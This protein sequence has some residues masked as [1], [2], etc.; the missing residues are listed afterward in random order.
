MTENK[1]FTIIVTYNAMKWIK[2]CLDA[3]SDSTVSTSI[4]VVDNASTDETIQYIRKNYPFVHIIENNANKGFGFANNQGIEYAY[5]QNA[6]HFFL[7]NQDLY[8][9]PDSIEELIKIQNVYNLPVVSPIHLSPQETPQ[10]DNAFFSYTVLSTRNNRMVTDLLLKRIKPYYNIGFVNAAA[11]I[12]SKKTI[13]HIGG[14]NPTFFHYGEDQDYANRLKFHNQS[15]AVIPTSF[16]THD[17]I[18]VGNVKQFNKNAL[19]SVFAI[20]CSNLNLS[21]VERVF[22]ISKNILISLCNVFRY[23]L[24]MKPSYAY[25]IIRALSLFCFRLPKIINH[26]NQNSIIQSNWLNI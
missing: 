11:W 19:Y 26:R 13:E 17:R 5:K 21:T 18:T 20:C 10:M 3:L 6:T 23:I 2:R 1:V 24:C 16:V 22:F 4:V 9:T 25:Y 7:C 14:F 8:V 12:I 15:I